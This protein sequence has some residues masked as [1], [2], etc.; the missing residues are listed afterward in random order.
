VVRDP[1]PFLQKIL[2]PFLV[3]SFGGA[4]ELDGIVSRKIPWRP[5]LFEQKFRRGWYIHPVPPVSSSWA[6]RIQR[7]KEINPKL[8][9]GVAAVKELL[10]E[11]EFLQT[12]HE[13]NAAILPLSFKN[14]TFAVEEVFPS[15]EDYI[16]GTRLKLSPVGARD[17][18]D[19]GL[20]RALV[21]TN[22][23]RKGVLLELVVA[24]FLSQVDGFEV[25]NI[26]IAN[27]SQQMDVLVHNRNTGGALGLSPIVLAEAKNWKE[28]V[29]TTEYV[30]FVR[31]LRSRHE[32]A[33]LGYL[34][35]TGRF[36]AGVELER[37][38]DSMDQ[39][40]VV[41]IDGKALPLLWRTNKTITACI[42]RITIAA[43]VGT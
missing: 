21:E 28:P 37:R 24:A 3:G 23:Q 33:K 4:V 10:G 12:C 32:R 41:L 34:I 9:I 16:C 17:I 13:L 25:D 31:K 1:I 18:L 2:R 42:E 15:V 22:K 30:V 27:R 20:L 7:A 36:T 14:D 5:H 38:R 6:E 35:T 40:L 26:G 43:T 19:R 8:R 39:T 11:E 29:D